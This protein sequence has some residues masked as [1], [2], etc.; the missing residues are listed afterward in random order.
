MLSLVMSQVVEPYMEISISFWQILGLQCAISR[1]LTHM[2]RNND[3]HQMA[4]V[5][6]GHELDAPSL[7]KSH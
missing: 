5:L 6:S 3:Y 1:F 4:L 7:Y 2:S